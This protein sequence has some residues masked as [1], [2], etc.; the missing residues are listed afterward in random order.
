MKVLQTVTAMAG[1]SAALNMAKALNNILPKVPAQFYVK[2]GLIYIL[3][4]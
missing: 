3:R 2:A 1:C 4:L